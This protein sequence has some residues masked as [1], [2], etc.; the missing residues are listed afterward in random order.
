MLAVEKGEGFTRRHLSRLVFGQDFSVVV[1]EKT[2][3]AR[4]AI[5]W[6]NFYTHACIDEHDHD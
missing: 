5:S 3:V 2:R 4:Q 1:A 6:T